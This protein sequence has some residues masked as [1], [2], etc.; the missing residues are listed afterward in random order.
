[1]VCTGSPEK[2]VGWAI[3][4]DKHHSEGLGVPRL[5]GF[6][7]YDDT[8]AYYAERS[9]HR[10]KHLHYYQVYAG[11][12]FGIIMLRLA[13]QL[14]HYGLMPEEAGHAF[15]RDNTVTRLTAKLLDMPPPGELKTPG[16]YT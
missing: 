15:E 2:D 14:V 10:V 16:S 3:F 8:L 7:S 4:L 13:Q 1:M 9:G 6:P 11:W 12:R 5:E